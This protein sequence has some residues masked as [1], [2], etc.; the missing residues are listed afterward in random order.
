MYYAYCKQVDD[1]QDFCDFFLGKFG[2]VHP[3][4]H[5]KPENKYPR[6]SRDKFN[7]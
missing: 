5:G 3:R 2:G 7:L 6:P 1:Q 4:K